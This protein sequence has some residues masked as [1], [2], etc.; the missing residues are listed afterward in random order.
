MSDY[1]DFLFYQ[2]KGLQAQAA[3]ATVFRG[4]A[5]GLKSKVN[6]LKSELNDTNEELA[7]AQQK[8]SQ[9]RADYNELCEKWNDLVHRNAELKITEQSL[10]NNLS[11]QRESKLK[12]L[13][14]RNELLA[15][16]EAEEKKQASLKKDVADA[17]SKTVAA[18][19]EAEHAELA[20][21]AQTELLRDSV[22]SSSR[23]FE[24]SR[25]LLKKCIEQDDLKKVKDGVNYI[26]DKMCELNTENVNELKDAE[27]FTVFKKAKNNAY[28]L[29]K[30]R[31]L[32]ENRDKKEG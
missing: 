2:N 32:K 15:Q 12:L 20:Y 16:L 1:S 26:A 22:N 28:T 25:K 29:Q 6:N 27:V 8:F 23:L 5:E 21:N 3:N 18:K 31:E 14:K 17:N 4:M 9:E 7:R 30:L 24:K 19:A 13:E 11:I 10:R